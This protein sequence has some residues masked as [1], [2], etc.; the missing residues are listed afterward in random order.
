MQTVVPTSLQVIAM[1]TQ[2]VAINPQLSL[3]AAM[4]TNLIVSTV[5]L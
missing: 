1:G 3:V 5:L 2:M 4:V